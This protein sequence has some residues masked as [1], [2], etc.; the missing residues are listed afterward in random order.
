MLWFDVDPIWP[1]SLHLFWDE[2]MQYISY[3]WLYRLKPLITCLFW[4][5]QVIIQ[6]WAVVLVFH[7]PR[8]T[9]NLGY[10]DGPISILYL[11]RIPNCI[12]LVQVTPTLSPFFLLSTP[13]LLLAPNKFY[14]YF[15][16]AITSI[17]GS[18]NSLMLCLKFDDLSRDLLNLCTMIKF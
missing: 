17:Y 5:Q 9:Q 16:L 2:N 6:V 12:Q 18:N 7:V 11:N 10:L 3:M 1:K 8:I 4:I 14:Y 15:H 13:K